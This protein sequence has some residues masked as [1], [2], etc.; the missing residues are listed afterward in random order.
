[1]MVIAKEC[2]T[3]LDAMIHC[4][5][6][7]LF[8]SENQVGSKGSRNFLL[9]KKKKNQHSSAQKKVMP[10]HCRTTEDLLNN[11]ASGKHFTYYDQNQCMM[12]PY[13]NHIFSLTLKTVYNENA[14]QNGMV[15][16]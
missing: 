6:H 16:A 3:T 8:H 10:K 1:M 4:N 9:I 5:I 7:C 15:S 2:D 13:T 11:E 14:S 12:L